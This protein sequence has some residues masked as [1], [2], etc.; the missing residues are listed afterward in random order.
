MSP[1]EAPCFALSAVFSLRELPAQ[2]WRMLG[3]LWLKTGQLD[4]ARHA[5][6]R[7]AALDVHDEESRRKLAALDSQ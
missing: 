7:A 3:E 6:A 5:F 2:S 4:F 1:F